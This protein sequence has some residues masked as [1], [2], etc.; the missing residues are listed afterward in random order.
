LSATSDEEALC[1]EMAAAIVHVCQMP[2]EQW[3]AMSDA[4]HEQ[5]HGYGWQD[6]A[7]VFEGLLQQA[8]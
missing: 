8:G 4:A 2:A 7:A 6:A 1:Q 5:A 3:Q